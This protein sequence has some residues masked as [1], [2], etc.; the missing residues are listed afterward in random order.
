MIKEM[1]SGLGLT[2]RTLFRHPVTVQYPD[3]KPKVPERYR[4]RIILTSDPSGEDRSALIVGTRECDSDSAEPHFPG[5]LDAV[6]VAVQ[7]HES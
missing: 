1:L 6:V 2:L 3:Q 7:V 4:G 5:F